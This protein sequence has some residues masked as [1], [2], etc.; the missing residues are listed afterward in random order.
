MI[1]INDINYKIILNKNINEIN[2]INYQVIWAKSK[3]EMNEKKKI[4]KRKLTLTALINKI[5][6]INMG[7]MGK[8]IN[9]KRNKHI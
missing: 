7:M 1:L 8:R 2:D 3:K 4:L 5:L 9:Y 6:K